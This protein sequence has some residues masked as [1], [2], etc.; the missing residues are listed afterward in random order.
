MPHKNH[1]RQQ[2]CT[3]PQILENVNCAIT[4][5]INYANCSEIT[6]I[7]QIVNCKVLL[8]VLAAEVGADTAENEPNVANKP[9]LLATFA[10][11][12]AQCRQYTSTESSALP[13]GQPSRQ[14]RSAQQHVLSLSE[15]TSGASKKNQSSKT[16]KFKTKTQTNLKMHQAIAQNKLSNKNIA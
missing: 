12:Q 7:A 4:R 11:V 10:S 14:K 13:T 3:A 5:I 1:R 15:K 8:P 2:N 9:N 6:S 16:N